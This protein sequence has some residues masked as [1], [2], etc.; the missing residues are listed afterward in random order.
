MIKAL[1]TPVPRDE[2]QFKY[3]PFLKDVMAPEAEI[4]VWF[5]VLT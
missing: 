1:T 5:N 4:M 2:F 3:R